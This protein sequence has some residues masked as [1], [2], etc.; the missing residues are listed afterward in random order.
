MS[1]GLGGPAP[2]D[3][4]DFRHPLRTVQIYRAEFDRRLHLGRHPRPDDRGSLCLRTRSGPESPDGIC[5]NRSLT[6]LAKN[7][8]TSSFRGFSPHN[9]SQNSDCALLRFQ[10]RPYH[11]ELAHY[12]VLFA[13]TKTKPVIS[14]VN[15]LTPEVVRYFNVVRSSQKCNDSPFCLHSESPFYTP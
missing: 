7:S 8:L 4:G 3:R 2:S 10:P 6:W 1:R 14:K 12:L 5:S 11:I 9:A 13:G 15:S